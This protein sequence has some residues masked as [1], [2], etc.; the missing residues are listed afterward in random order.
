MGIHQF[1]R[2]VLKPHLNTVWYGYGYTA[3]GDPAGT[4][5]AQS[6]E[7]TCFQELS[8]QGIPA[9]P[10]TTNEPV[11]RREAVA[12]YLL[13][14]CGP[15]YPGL[16]VHPRCQRI[17]TGFLGGYCYKRVHVAGKGDMTREIPEKNVYSHPH[18]A[19]QYAALWTHMADSTSF[20]KKIDYKERVV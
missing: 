9:L 17:R 8:D 19:L 11:A 6:D 20:M 3:V 15:K 13:K 18:D 14:N 1:A 5:R 10:A 16:I 4:S 7:K 2:D 12:K